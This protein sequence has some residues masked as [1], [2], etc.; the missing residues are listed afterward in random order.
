MSSAKQ[1]AS[2]ELSEVSGGGDERIK[3]ILKGKSREEQARILVEEESWY[4]KVLEVSRDPDPSYHPGFAEYNVLSDESWSRRN[5]DYRVISAMRVGGF[6]D[7]SNFVSDQEEV[8]LVLDE[9]WVQVF[10]SYGGNGY[11]GPKT[12]EYGF[13]DVVEL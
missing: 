11:M 9:G 7:L 2:D 5:E 3:D 6:E 8:L 10:A 1:Q 4:D 13:D 12:A